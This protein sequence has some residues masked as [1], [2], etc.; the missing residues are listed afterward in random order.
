M[1]GEGPP[2]VASALAAPDGG[3]RG[4]PSVSGEGPLSVSSTLASA[5]AVGA[6]VP[7]V[8]RLA[9]VMDGHADVVACLAF[10]PDGFLVSGRR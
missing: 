10:S 8:W 4:P 1:S 5:S 6:E 7:L 9:A 2:S 3:E